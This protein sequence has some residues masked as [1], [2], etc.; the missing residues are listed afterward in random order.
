MVPTLIALWSSCFTLW[1]T[2]IT[3]S[4]HTNANYKNVAARIGVVMR[5][6]TWEFVGLQNYH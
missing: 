3:L 2:A 4:F 1:L 5:P 6:A